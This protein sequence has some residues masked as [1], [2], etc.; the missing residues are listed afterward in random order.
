MVPLSRRTTLGLTAAA[1]AQ[2]ALPSPA[3]AGEAIRVPWSAGDEA[4]TLVTPPHAT[5]C[6][7]H[8]YDHH[9]PPAPEATLHPGD[10][11]V[12]DYRLLQ[13][14][15]GI[16]RHV[17]V[18]PSTYGTDNRLLLDALAA[19]GPEARGVAV[20]HPD[21]SEGELRR[22]DAAGVRGVRFNLVQAGATTLEMIEPLSRRIAARGWHVQVHMRGED[23]AAAG[24]L[25]MKLPTPIVFD[26]FGRIPL[27]EGTT[28]P[29]FRTIAALLERGRAWVK[30]SGAYIVSR[31]GPPDYADV[32]PLA[33][34]YAAAAP[35]RLVWGSDW[36]HPT[37]TVKPDDAVLLDLLGVWVPDAALRQR[38]LVE[39]PARLYG[40]G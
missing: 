40:F 25:W 2:H 27:P 32:A 16:Q 34:A 9:Y 38:I 12:A 14:R 4:P 18:Q 7:H 21:V 28:S 37:E 33:R 29:A 5:D 36:P 6:H 13:K 39:N 26:H 30:L 8:I 23:I 3:S 1:L 19:F 20:L 10:A 15:L 35:E 17:V 11:T 24:N 22:L 31:Q